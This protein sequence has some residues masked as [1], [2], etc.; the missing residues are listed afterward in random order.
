MM[1]AGTATFVACAVFA[2]LGAVVGASAESYPDKPIR[3][4]VATSPG[5]TSDIF[6][7]AAGEE[8]YKRTGQ[9][10]VVENRSGGAMN[11]GAEACANG[12]NDGYTICILPN[13]S[14]AL[15]Q[16]L[17]KELP[18]NPETAFVPITNPFFNPQVIVASAALKVRS[19]AELAAASK[20]APGKLSYSALS[21]P[22]QMFIEEWKKKTGADLVQVPARGGGDVATGV[23]TG[24]VPVAIVGVP[25]WL[26]YIR[27]GSE[28][29]LAVNTTERLPLLPD[30]PTL[31][32]L[33]YADAAQM[34]F[35]IVAPAKTPTSAVQK[36][37]TEFRAIGD[38][39][40]FRRQRLTEQGLVPVFDSPEEFQSSLAAERASAK[41]LFEESGMEKR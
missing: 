11:I 30:V 25:N 16:Y 41:R 4:I 34:Y 22:M 31:K 9:R 13:E 7:R 37:Y 19:M 40:D 26:P 2:S 24:T 15:N 21:V 17:Y 3:V 20:A 6:I 8:F 12:S 1:R 28:V 33:G 36:L 5:G 39:P 35:G 29:P 14:L 10:L 32:E 23:M 27:D 38:E 18:Y